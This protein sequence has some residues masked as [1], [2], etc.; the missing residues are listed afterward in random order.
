MRFRLQA[1]PRTVRRSSVICLW[2]LCLLLEGG[3]AVEAQSFGQQTDVAFAGRLWEALAEHGYVG[4]KA[5]RTRPY[6]GIHPHGAVLERIEATLSLPEA[7]GPVLVKKTYRGDDVSVEAVA[8]DPTTYLNRIAV[9]FR[10]TDYAPE[11]GD[12]FWAHYDPDGTLVADSTGMRRAGRVAKDS[13][14]GCIACHRRAPGG[15]Y[16]FGHNRFAR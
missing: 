15:D 7:T 14:T 4:S 11:A 3:K 16:V 5:L 8:E 6:P 12:W 13:D 2:V 9:M 10:R 1:S